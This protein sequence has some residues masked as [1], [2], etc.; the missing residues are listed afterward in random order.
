M[1]DIFGKHSGSTY[2]E[3]LVDCTSE[4]DFSE[5]LEKC[6]AIWNAH[7]ASYAPTSGP[8]FFNYFIWYKS[9]TVCHSMRADLRE[10]V[11]LGCPPDFTTNASETINAMMKR[12]VNYEESEWPQ[13]SEEIKHFMKQQREEIIRALSGRG[14]HHW[15]QQFSHYSVLPSKWAKMGPEQWREIIVQFDKATVKSKR[16]SPGSTSASTSTLAEEPSEK[17]L[18]VSTEESGIT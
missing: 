13:F 14:Q 18:C 6:G 1:S 8:Q 15:I 3:G 2:N 4:K 11:G 17:R 7:E 12:K 9:D 5:R 10:S 16:S